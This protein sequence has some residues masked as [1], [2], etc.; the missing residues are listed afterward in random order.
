M[1]LHYVSPSALPSRS[2]NSVHVVL[3][4]QGLQRA[5]AEVLLYARRMVVDERELPDAL[6]RTYG[7]DTHGWALRTCHPTPERGATL[8]IAMHALPWL[9]RERR[10]AAVLSRNLYASFAWAVLM[11]R[12]MLFETHQLE[13]GSRKALQRL[14]MCQPHVLTVA[15][16]QRL[17]GCLEEHHGVAP[18][19]SLVLHDAAPDGIVPC[20]PEAR[21]VALVE[22]GVDDAARW[23]QVCGYFG[24]LYAGRG[25][26]VIEEMA[27]ARPDVLF[28]VYGG[29]EVDIE[30]RRREATLSNLRF[31]GH[32]P[33]P[34]ARAAM[35]AV[36][37]LLMPYQRQVSI[38]ISAHDT[39]R[40]M[41][42][43]KMFEYMAA[44]VPL[45]SSDLPVLREVLRDGHNGLLVPP[46]EPAAWVAAIDRLRADP[47]EAAAIGQRA[48]R[49][50]LDHYSWSRRGGALLDA[51]RSL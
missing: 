7:V 39:A 2:A 41:S 33:H 37:A 24:Q 14:I 18:R 4:C 17:V 21:R 31:M 6:S 45:V 32:V 28:L 13:L 29:N 3:Q 44:G 11:R 19:Q 16:S 34:T 50:Y 43:M 42:P 38:G 25:I 30:A 47:Q 12:P 48:H 10:D 27:R 36:D 51:A 40:W 35:V 49:E 20:A 8:R 15:I 22:L 26:E 23:T 1:R 9:W 5:G 46:D